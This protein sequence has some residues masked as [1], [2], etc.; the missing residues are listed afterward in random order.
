MKKIKVNIMSLLTDIILDE[1]TI[2]NIFY[3]GKDDELIEK[4]INISHK[5]PN[6]ISRIKVRTVLYDTSK[7]NLNIILRIPKGAVNTDTFLDIKTLLVSE[8]ASATIIP[9]LEI[10]EN[11]VKGGHGAVVGYLDMNQIYY[12][13]SK[14]LNYETAEKLLIK[15]FLN[16]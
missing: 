2:L 15:A 8:N 10:Q 9:S 16:S 6:I 4:T 5:T 3:V 12:L 11:E 14:G 13:L 7:I 1:N